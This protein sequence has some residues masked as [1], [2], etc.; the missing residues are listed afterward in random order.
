VL[1]STNS[2]VSWT[3]LD[4]A[5]PMKQA[6]N[7]LAFSGNHLLAGSSGSGVYWINLP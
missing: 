6:Y 4:Q 7:A 5:L 1:I 2:G 3:Y